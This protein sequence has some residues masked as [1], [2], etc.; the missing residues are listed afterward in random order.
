MRIPETVAAVMRRMHEAGYACHA[1]GGCV[2]DSLMGKE[3]HDWD[4]TTNALP[5]QVAALF[6][7]ERVIPTG[8]A[9]GT[10]TV[11][12]NGMPLE[13]TTYRIDGAYTDHRRP[14]SVSFV[15]DITEDLRRRD[16]TV[17]AMAYAPESGLCDP[18]GG[19]EDLK[20][21]V[22]RCVG[23]AEERFDEDA[24][25][26]LRALR[27][28]STYGFTIEEATAAALFAKAPLL[29]TVA[30]ERVR[31]ELDRLLVGEHVG[32]VLER[33]AAVLFPVLPELEA[34]AGVLQ[35]NPYHDRDVLGH[36]IASV[37][38]SAAVL[39]VRLA[40]LLHDC[41]K[42]GHFAPIREGFGHFPDHPA[43]GAAMAK[44]ALR[45]LRYDRKTEETV[46]RL[47]QYHD[48]P[49]P[50]TDAG[51]RRWLSRMGEQE[52]RWLLDVKE[53]DCRGHAANLPPARQE[54]ICRLRERIAR[55]VAQGQ[56]TSLADLAIDGETLIRNGI[57][58]GPSVGRCLHFALE[59]VLDGDL[60]NERE[61]LLRAISD[62]KDLIIY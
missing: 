5:E 42:P 23:R 11:L 24:L 43:V 6:A 17:N 2:R 19:A 4:L 39:P 27:F 13:I 40:L 41:G 46:C 51:V 60:P 54:E 30:A 61:A 26:I 20:N 44:T 29:K 31:A 9:H 16:F 59:R 7:D 48:S 25:R 21:G 14:D 62:E 12:T 35:Y 37:A 28:A 56:C 52:L 10:V 57:P 32:A 45:R 22:L 8:M 33:F 53:G 18:F 38:S 49:I 34:E 15:T 55:V 3:P 36:T 50:E 1:V 58:A 47:I